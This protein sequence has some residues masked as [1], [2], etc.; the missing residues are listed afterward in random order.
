VSACAEFRAMLLEAEPEELRAEGAG[1]LA[2]HLRGCPE[3]ARLAALVLQETAQLDRYLGHTPGFD[4]DALL[5]RAGFPLSAP[6]L[7]EKQPA[8]SGKVAAGAHNLFPGRRLW[9][10]LATAAA[11]AALLLFRGPQARRAAPYVA[12]SP[13]GTAPAPLVEPVAG[14]DAA[15]MKTDDPEITVVWLFS[16]G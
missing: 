16:T 1:A 15:I 4:V 6:P 7:I 5:K 8:G 9:I 14:Q 10:P 12:S 3:C 11:V 2:V 13:T